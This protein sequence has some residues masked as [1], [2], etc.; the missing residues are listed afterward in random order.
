MIKKRF[1]HGIGVKPLFYFI[2]SECQKMLLCR[3]L[4]VS[5]GLSRKSQFPVQDNCGRRFI[6]KKVYI[7]GVAGIFKK[8][9]TYIGV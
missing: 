5:N 4:L 8:C 6:G 2:G 9:Y 3:K 7:F 1:S